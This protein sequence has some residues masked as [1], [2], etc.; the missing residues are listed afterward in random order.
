MR[1]PL[2][3]EVLW[4]S[5]GSGH[6][7]FA[8]YRRRWG[9]HGGPAWLDGSAL[10]AWRNGRAFPSPGLARGG[11]IYSWQGLRLRFL[12]HGLHFVLLSA[13]PNERT[14]STENILNFDVRTPENLWLNYRECTQSSAWKQ[15]GKFLTNGLNTLLVLQHVFWVLKCTADMLQSSLMSSLETNG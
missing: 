13:P 7:R 3:D 10:E 8:R 15:L 5:V 11:S 4:F 6:H 9:D 2:G 1:L 14:K 12:L